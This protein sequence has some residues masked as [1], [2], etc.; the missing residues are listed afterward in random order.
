M[1][2]DENG[3]AGH[4]ALVYASFLESAHTKAPCLRNRL[5]DT[6]SISTS[7]ESFIT[8]LWVTRGTSD[9]RRITL[10]FQQGIKEFQ[11]ALKLISNRLR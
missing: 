7:V 9:F 8:F 11:R 3:P 6:C 5:T 1:T 4:G 10:Y 2:S